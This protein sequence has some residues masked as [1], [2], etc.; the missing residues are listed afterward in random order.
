V[1]LLVTRPLADGRRLAEAL[2][3]RGHAA[4]LEPLLTIE[5]TGRAP[6]LAGVQAL[7]A[8]S[9]HGVAAFAAL[10]ADRSLPLYA[11][12]SATA[13]TARQ[14]GFD[15]V[16][17]AGGNARA[18]AASLA[19]DLEPAAG[20]VLHLAGAELAQDLAALLAPGGPPVRQVCLYRA[21]P[22]KVLSVRVRTA[23]EDGQLDGATFFSPRSAATFVRLTQEAGLADRL[24]RLAAFCLSP[25]VAASLAPTV[26]AAVAVAAAPKL[27]ALLDSIA[28][29]ARDRTDA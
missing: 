24:A 3:A 9:R 12:G 13:A 28:A 27:A 11:V 22:A 6:A 4:L 7:A 23:L 26:W 21:V 20:C 1:R 25:A 8:T 19:A 16:V 29:Y 18:L 14:A 15:R 2:A 10:S 5:T 17:Q